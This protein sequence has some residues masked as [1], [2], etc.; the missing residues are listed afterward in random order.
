MVTGPAACLFRCSSR[1]CL[2]KATLLFRVNIC[3]TRSAA[4]EINI[5]KL[6]SER[7]RKQ[8]DNCYLRGNKTHPDVFWATAATTPSVI[9]SNSAVTLKPVIGGY[10]SWDGTLE[11]RK[12]PSERDT[13]GTIGAVEA[14]APRLLQVHRY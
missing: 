9:P 11:G 2:S 13:K 10:M 8:I 12:G 4:R 3:Y 6:T 14:W 1:N 5:Y 7:R